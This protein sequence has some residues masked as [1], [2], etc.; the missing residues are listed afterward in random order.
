M[1]NGVLF[2]S[3]FV[4][5]NVCSFPHMVSFSIKR[6]RITPQVQVEQVE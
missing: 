2:S 6:A 1:F 4:L 5:F 3:L